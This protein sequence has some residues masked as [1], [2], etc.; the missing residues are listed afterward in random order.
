MIYIELNQFKSNFFDYFGKNNCN[1]NSQEQLSNPKEE[2]SVRGG[3][4]DGPEESIFGFGRG[5]GADE[6]AFDPNWVVAR[7]KPQY[8]EIFKK[9][10]PHDGKVSG[11][12]AKDELIKSKLPNTVLSRV[13][14]LADCDGD[15]L[16]DSDE[17]ALAMHLINVKLSGHELPKELPQHLIPPSKKGT[18]DE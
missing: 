16:L 1:Y 13:W 14:R 12:Q 4:F 17:F 8:D 9:L 15:G 2:S 7:D 11:A 5:E 6:G 18:A 3:A 10:N